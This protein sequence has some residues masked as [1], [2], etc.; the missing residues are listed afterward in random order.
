MY[1]Y[2]YILVSVLVLANR[3][4]RLASP[5]QVVS[6]TAHPEALELIAGHFCASSALGGKSPDNR[7]P[8]AGLD[9]GL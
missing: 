8:A 5:F 9:M 2:M 4:I 7:A 3:N 1:M 6:G